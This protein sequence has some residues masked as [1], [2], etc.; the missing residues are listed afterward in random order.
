MMEISVT[1][2]SLLRD[3]T[4]NRTGFTL[5]AGTVAEA[6][7]ELLERYPLLRF[8]LYDDAEQLRRHVLLYY[9]DQNLAWLP[10]LDVPLRPGD[11]LT[12][13]QN[14]SGG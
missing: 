5:E 8:H 11:E 1:V 3:C 4:E 9:N 13:V 7:R 10:S 12:V 14:V 2:P 6:L